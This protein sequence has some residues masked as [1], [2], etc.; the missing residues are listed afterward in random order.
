MPF[1]RIIRIRSS[2]TTAIPLELTAD[3]QIVLSVY[4]IHGRLVRTLHKGAMAA[5]VTQVEWD[6]RDSD[7]SP[8]SSWIYFYRLHAM[9]DVAVRKMVLLK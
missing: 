7:G 6:G 4:D 2:A 1:S 9:N 8:A 5:G 3:Q